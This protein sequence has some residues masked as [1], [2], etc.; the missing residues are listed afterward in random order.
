MSS[1]FYLTNST[2]FAQNILHDSRQHVPCCY[3]RILCFLDRASL[4]NLANKSN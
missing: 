3:C 4:Y 2:H 1:L